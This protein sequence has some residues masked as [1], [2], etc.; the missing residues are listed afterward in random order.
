MMIRIAQGTSEWSGK[1]RIR[2]AQRCGWLALMIGVPGIAGS[3]SPVSVSSASLAKPEHAIESTKLARTQND[4][5]KKISINI[6]NIPISEAIR[7][8][9]RQGNV[10]LVYSADILPNRAT[11]LRSSS[12]SVGDALR[13]VLAGTDIRVEVSSSGEIGLTKGSAKAGQQVTTGKISGR[14]VDSATKKPIP[15]AT[16]VLDG[17]KLAA[18]AGDNGGFVIENAPTGTHS[19]RVRILGYETK[20]ISVTVKKDETASVS[21][22]LKPAS[23]TLAEIRTTAT[24][25]R[26][27]YEVGSDITRINVDEVRKYKEVNTVF[28]VLANKVPGMFTQSGG[29]NVGAENLLRIRGVHSISLSNNPIVIIDGVRMATIGSEGGL[30]SRLN[31]IDPASIETIEVFKG[32]SAATLYGPDASNGVIVIT[33]KRGLVGSTRWTFTANKNMSENP[34]TFPGVLEAWGHSVE[35]YDAMPCTANRGC[36][37]RDSVRIASLMNDDSTSTIGRGRNQNFG[38]SLL[39]G[40]NTAQTALTFRMSDVVGVSKLSDVARSRLERLTGRPV[41]S[42][43]LQ[44]NTQQQL[45]ADANITM[46]TIPFMDAAFQV[47]VMRQALRD[48]GNAIYDGMRQSAEYYKPEVGFLQRVDEVSNQYGTTL[49]LKTRQLRLVNWSGTVGVSNGSSVYDR[50]LRPEDCIALDCANAKGRR[51]TMDI[52]TR[53]Y[54]AN[55]WVG[56]NYAISSWLRS[57][58]TAGLNVFRN[59]R[60]N[61]S[62]N[63]G[64]MSIGMTDPTRAPGANMT[65][66]VDESASAGA[67]FE[68]RLSFGDKLF[69][70]GAIRRDV[71]STMGSNA[72]TPTFPKFDLSWIVSQKPIDIPVVGTLNTVRVRTSHGQSGHQPTMGNLKARLTQGTAYYDGKTTTSY[73]F[74]GLGNSIIT[75]ERA[76]EAEYGIDF[77]LSGRIENL[78]ITYFRHLTHQ[79]IVS[80]PVSVEAGLP[81]NNRTENLG[82]LQNTGFEMST[83]LRLIDTRSIDWNMNVSLSHTGNKVLSLGQYT[84]LPSSG[85]QRVVVGHPVFGMWTR[86]LLSAE[87]RNQDGILIFDEVVMGDTAVYAGWAQPKYSVSYGTSVGLFGGFI[88]VSTS[89]AQ[90]VGVTKLSQGLPSTGDALGDLEGQL[91]TITRVRGLQTVSSLSWNSVDVSAQLPATVLRQIRARS[92]TMSVTASNLYLWTNFRGTDPLVG[93]ISDGHMADKGTTPLTRNWVLRFSLS[94]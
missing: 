75:A 85:E 7:Q 93:P 32:A 79:A 58:S 23:T 26:H 57:T 34:R 11:S 40:S 87:D 10:L 25:E 56:A 64:S 47:T 8:I 24:G 66:L 53:S 73:V 36:V 9:A 46:Q 59:R 13:A 2:L 91:L 16:I 80:R 28:D 20:I 44:P 70:S 29:G 69:V 12:I 61:F 82:K 84:A 67:Y 18:V 94:Y 5:T 37:G 77:D 90:M 81:D 60:E 52:S 41:P 4:V 33:K 38:I 48:G 31:D 68:E 62:V 83:A 22:S 72:K 14:V 54:T 30:S 51:T 19:L 17:T 78:S 65:R 55:S 76:T 39:T 49:Q 50:W 42:H 88:R 89:L 45:N 15:R 63:A 27:S 35:S 92:G 43:A 74:E 3:Q 71:S 21:I 6:Q 86:P 1:P